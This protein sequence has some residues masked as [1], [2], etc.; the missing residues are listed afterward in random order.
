MERFREAFVTSITCIA[1]PSRK[2][3]RRCQSPPIAL[4]TRGPLRRVA[5]VGGGI[6][7]LSTAIAL[8]RQSSLDLEE[9][10]VFERRPGLDT[11]QGGALNLTGGA[12]V[13][14]K[15]FDLGHDISTIGNPLRRIRGRTGEAWELYDIRVPQLLARSPRGRQSCFVGDD[16]IAYTVMRDE[17]QALLR[18][19]LAAQVRVLYG[20]EVVSVHS[21]G[22]VT[23]RDPS[24]HVNESQYDLVVGADGI[25]SKVREWVVEEAFTPRSLGIRYVPLKHFR[26]GI[27]PDNQHSPLEFSLQFRPTPQC[28]TVNCINGSAM[29]AMLSNILLVPETVRGGSLYSY[30]DPPR[31]RWKT[32]TTKPPAPELNLC[33]V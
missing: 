19:N 23:T 3:T 10:T 22:R 2:Q 28:Q 7:G 8:E 9:L 18:K 29:A 5:I 13:L 33:S 11:E 30:R 25:R 21:D 14:V 15:Q 4:E 24:G 20:T 26:Q 32:S 31:W 1:P 16:C 17:L 6:A 27:S 12:S